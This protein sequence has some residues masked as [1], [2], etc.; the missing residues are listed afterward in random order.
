MKDFRSKYTLD[1]PYLFDESQDVAK[2]Y[3]A[4]CTPDFFLYNAKRKLVYRGQMDNS[5][6]GNQEINDGHCLLKAAEAIL[7]DQEALQKQVPSM[8]CNIKWRAGNEPT[9]YS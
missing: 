5:R 2:S 9:Y 8:G 3:K 7:H 1:I 4:S 6:P